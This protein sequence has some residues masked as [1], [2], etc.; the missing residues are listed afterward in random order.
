MFFRMWEPSSLTCGNVHIFVHFSHDSCWDVTRSACICLMTWNTFSF[1]FGIH[2]VLFMVNPIFL[3]LICFISSRY[4]ILLVLVLICNFVSSMVNYFS[5]KGS[6]TA[7]GYCIFL[8][9][10]GLTLVSL[11][12]MTSR[13]S[14]VKHSS[15]K[16]KMLSSQIRKKLQFPVQNFG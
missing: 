11:E 2:I 9:H 7:Q 3:S 6:G 5:F 4:Y 8:P 13:L 14:L 15:F 1:F 10:H 16:E 12:Y